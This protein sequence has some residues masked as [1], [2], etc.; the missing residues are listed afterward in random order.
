MLK[1]FLDPQKE[2]RRPLRMG[3]GFRSNMARKPPGGPLGGTRKFYRTVQIGEVRYR[4]ENVGCSSLRFRI[5][6]PG[7]RENRCP[8]LFQ[9]NGIGHYFRRRERMGEVIT[10]Y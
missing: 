5:R 9:L 10:T 8:I 4:A 7:I 2:R 6:V 3:L 1:K